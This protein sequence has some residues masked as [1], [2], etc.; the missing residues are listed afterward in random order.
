MS[1]FFTNK[2][3]GRAQQEISR[4]D[5]EFHWNTSIQIQN[6]SCIP[7]TSILRKKKRER[8]HLKYLPK[9]ISLQT[10]PPK[11]KKKNCYNKNCTTWKKE[12]EENLD[13]SLLIKHN[14]NIH[15]KTRRSQIA[16]VI[17][18]KKINSGGSRTPD[19]ETHMCERM[20]L[21][22]KHVKGCLMKE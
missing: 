10:N 4:F 20:F 21:Y 12:I 14:L 2:I 15:L 6:L 1:L 22:S 11:Y 7:I 9:D 13:V 17:L 5:G 8:P 19:L 16:S 3:P 18:S